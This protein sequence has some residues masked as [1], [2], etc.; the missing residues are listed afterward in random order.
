MSDRAYVGALSISAVYS[1]FASFSTSL[2]DE[3]LINFVKGLK[4][5]A[6]LDQTSNMITSPVRGAEVLRVPTKPKEN[7]GK[8][9]KETIGEKLMNIGVRAIYGGNEPQIE[10]IPLT[11]R[12]KNTYYH[13]YQLEFS[14]RVR[15]SK[16]PVRVGV[17]P[18]LFHSWQM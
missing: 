6:I 5:V 3:S 17:P 8:D 7:L 2:S 11:E 18:F 16:H 1:R 10:D 12:T 14:R 15:S 4:E 9:E 13:D